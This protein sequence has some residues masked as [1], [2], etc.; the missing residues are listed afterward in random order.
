VQNSEASTQAPPGS[1]SV[2]GDAAVFGAYGWDPGMSDADILGILVA[3][4]LERAN[5]EESGRSREAPDGTIWAALVDTGR[6][7]L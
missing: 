2:D 4:N 7:D 6:P 5:R 3:L 1:G